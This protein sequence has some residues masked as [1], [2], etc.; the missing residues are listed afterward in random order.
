MQSLYWQQLVPKAQLLVTGML[1]PECEPD[2]QVPAS[3]TEKHAGAAP[4]QHGITQYCSA[5]HVVLPQ[6]VG[7]PPPLFT[8]LP[9]VALL[10]PGL[11]EPPT[12]LEPAFEL[13]PALT[14]SLSV[15]LHAASKSDCFGGVRGCVCQGL[16]Q[17]PRTEPHPGPIDHNAPGRAA[18]RR[19][20]ARSALGLTMSLR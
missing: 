4:P 9:P 5:L 16:C 7:P 17:M 2:G 13:P 6:V 15:P 14:V 19:A 1:H 10:P 20:L 12:L 11:V 3:S 18:I 8:E